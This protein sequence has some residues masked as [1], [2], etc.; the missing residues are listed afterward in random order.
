MVNGPSD[1][2]FFMERDAHNCKTLYVIAV[3]SCD[4]DILWFRRIT[5]MSC[6]QG[7]DHVPRECGV[8]D[9]GKYSFRSRIKR[10]FSDRNIITVAERFHYTVS[11]AELYA[12]LS[13]DF[14]KCDVVILLVAVQPFCCCPSLAALSSCRNLPLRSIYLLSHISLPRSR[15]RWARLLLDFVGYVLGYAGPH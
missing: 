5:S 4:V 7:R 1:S 8:H 3:L 14:G 13:P 11:A 10:V 15:C 12:I 6:C 9:V 2:G